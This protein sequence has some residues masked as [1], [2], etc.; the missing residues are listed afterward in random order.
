MNFVHD[1]VVFGDNVRLY[2]TE[3]D[4]NFLMVSAIFFGE[5]EVSERSLIL[6]K[7]VLEVLTILA[8]FLFEF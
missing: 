1:L 6:V 8:H 3:I 4:I 7:C 2:M 5:G